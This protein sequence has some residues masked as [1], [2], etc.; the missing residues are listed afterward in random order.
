MGSKSVEHDIQQAAKVII[1]SS[2]TESTET[3]IEIPLN[4]DTLHSQIP[5]QQIL[6]K[7]LFDCVKFT[8]QIQIAIPLVKDLLLSKNVTDVQEAI[9]FF[10]IAHKFGVQDAIQGIRAMIVLIWSNEKSIKEAIVSAYRRVYLNND[11]EG[12]NERARAAVVVKSLSELVQGA[13]LGE[14]ISLEHLLKEFMESE[15]IGHNH[16]LIM[17][18]RFAMKLPNTTAEESRVAVQ[19]IGMLASSKEELVRSNLSVLIDVGL[20]ERAYQDSRL[21]YETS[22]ALS[23]AFRVPKLESKETF[24]RLPKT[25]ELFERLSNILISGITQIEDKFWPMLCN[26][27]IKMIF[28][29]AENPDYICEQLVRNIIK[30]LLKVTETDS[31]IVDSQSTNS[32]SQNINPEAPSEQIPSSQND[33]SKDT[34]SQDSQNTNTLLENSKKLNSEIL[35]RFLTLLGDVALNML[36]HLDTSILTELKI[37][38]YLKDEKENKNKT[39]TP[40]RRSKTPKTP[41]SAGG[42]QNLEEE[43]G[44]G[45]AGAI[46]DQ[47]QECLNKVCDE[48]VVLGNIYDWQYN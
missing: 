17:W 40:R 44:L 36:V 14:L 23:K 33:N 13:T 9:E 21:A 7:Y 45:G 34:A 22:I 29:L 1:Q 46:D 31:L 18:E 5:K 42:D 25:H 48:E 8:E 2:Q 3:V 35:A 28:K 12:R 41:G 26:E 39:K 19:L 37:R 10:V 47:E 6:V 11:E 15:D 20:G 24:F 4:S 38:N 27:S 43:I 16:I 30:E 32:E